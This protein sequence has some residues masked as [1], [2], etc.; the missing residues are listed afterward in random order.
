MKHFAV[1]VP[2]FEMSAF[3]P[4]FDK[5][6]QE[7]FSCA[8]KQIPPRSPFSKGGGRRT[9]SQDQEFIFCRRA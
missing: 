5:G 9:Q 4:A 2:S 1:F 3:L 8:S 7:G 6:E